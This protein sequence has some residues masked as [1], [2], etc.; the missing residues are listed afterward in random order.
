MYSSIYRVQSST[1][2][3]PIRALFGFT[4]KLVESYLSP[5]P[6]SLCVW[7][8]VLGV[9]LGSP[10]G[11]MGDVIDGGAI[12]SGNW[13]EFEMA[14]YN[15]TFH[16]HF[17]NRDHVHHYDMSIDQCIYP[18]LEKMRH[19]IMVHLL[20]ISVFSD[21]MAP[22]RCLVVISYIFRWIIY[23][24]SL[25]P[26]LLWWPYISSIVTD[27]GAEGFEQLYW[28]DKVDQLCLGCL[29]IVQDNV[30]HRLSSMM[31]F[32]I[33]RMITMVFGMINCTGLIELT[34]CVWAVCIL[35][36]TIYTIDYHQWCIL[37]SWEW[38]PWCVAWST[39]SGRIEM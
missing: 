24:F 34:S 31:Y 5:S 11:D 23:L 20:F 12:A 32:I 14:L 22:S 25:L 4:L 29:H 15:F 33:L 27:D 30:H 3:L 16:C 17:N 10:Q 19:N 7:W 13:W 18:L 2:R 35:F 1:R 36:K 9:N 21:R 26:Q 38:S 8:F 6:Q 37:L 28:A 39:V